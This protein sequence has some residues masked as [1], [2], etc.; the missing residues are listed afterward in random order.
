MQSRHRRRVVLTIAALLI[1]CGF[2]A[3]KSRGFTSSRPAATPTA[4]ATA[5]HAPA[6][7]TFS[8]E[9]NT[10][11][12]AAR[13]PQPLPAANR[14]AVKT[15][16]STREQAARGRAIPEILAG[17]DMADP[18]TRARV[19]A[20][21]EQLEL[22]QKQA[23]LAKARRLGIPVRI[24]GPGRKLSILHD[25]RGIQPMEIRKAQ[26]CPDYPETACF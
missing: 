1:L 5:S 20:A 23:V 9:P 24:E 12:T 13:A 16:P 3:W 19:V 18:A 4:A 11:T 26:I 15:R 7:E 6:R 17:A 14:P 22:R 10:A 21:I 8:S 2:V 25:F